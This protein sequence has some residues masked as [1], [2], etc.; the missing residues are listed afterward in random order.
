MVAIESVDEFRLR[1]GGLMKAP[2]ADA[3][4][5]IEQDRAQ[6][7]RAALEEAAVLAQ[8]RVGESKEYHLPQTALIAQAIADDIRALN[9]RSEP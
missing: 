6:V 8:K 3:R 4:R 9:D 7:R 2:V 5:A 1:F